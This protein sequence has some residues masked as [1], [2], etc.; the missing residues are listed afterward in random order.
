MSERESYPHGV[1]CWV[2]N[3]WPEPEAGLRFYG[4]VL[5]WEFEG[6]GEMPG[7]PPGQYFVATLEGRDVAGI[8]SLPS[9][10]PAP[11]PAWNTYVRV[12]SADR[13]AAA[14]RDA[15]GQVSVEPFDAPPAGRMAVV[16][17]PAGAA[18]SV[19]EAG[20]REGAQRVNEPGAWSMSA[21]RTS[22]PEG[23]Q[24]F[25]GDVFGWQAEPFGPPE[26]GIWMWR[27]PG[28]VG[29]EP[30]QP[31]PRDVVATMVRTDEGEPN[32]RPD[33]WIAD[34]DGAAAKA[35]EL[36][37]HVVEAPADVPGIPFRSALLADGHGATFSLSQLV[38]EGSS[39]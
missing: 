27:L 33:F 13:A 29:G 15:G 2:D 4:A 32:W 12:D 9:A 19:W 23:V 25:Y 7:E 10:D 26:A 3:A 18:F 31:V 6:P 20:I 16:A 38:L 35:A 30:D 17:D 1:P 37:G 8:S 28:Y 21:L 34:V 39:S 5:G 24:G 11:T 22:D 36:G 14:V